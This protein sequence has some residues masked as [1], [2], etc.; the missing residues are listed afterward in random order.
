M[1]P[2]LTV[3]TPTNPKSSNSWSQVTGPP[4]ST[5]LGF[6]TRGNWICVVPGALT[7]KISLN[8]VASC[9]VSANCVHEHCGIHP[10][11]LYASIREVQNQGLSDLWNPRVG[12]RR[13]QCSETRRFVIVSSEASPEC[14]DS[15][16]RLY[17]VSLMYPILKNYTKLVAKKF[18][19]RKPC[20]KPSDNDP[21]TEEI[22]DQKVIKNCF[23]T[24]FL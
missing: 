22:R 6:G 14:S 4:C 8:I 21:P 12:V 5:I 20:C 13:G 18:V 19:I 17:F 23:G 1:Q 10:Q 2:G 24:H 16:E 15:T 9:P 3:K 7:I 11:C